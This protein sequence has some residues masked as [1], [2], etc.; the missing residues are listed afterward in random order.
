MNKS[1]S[2]SYI[3]FSTFSLKKDNFYGRRKKSGPL[4][5]DIVLPLM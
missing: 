2:R 3:I 5:K 1:T 4:L